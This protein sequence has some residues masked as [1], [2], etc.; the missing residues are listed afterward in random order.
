MQVNVN[1]QKYLSFFLVNY[2]FYLPTLPEIVT[3]EFV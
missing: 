1:I 2:D 3:F